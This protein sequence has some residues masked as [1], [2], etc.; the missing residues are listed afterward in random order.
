[1]TGAASVRFGD[2][3]FEL[4]AERVAWWA[5]A[6][7]V[8][9]ADL[10]WGKSQTFRALGVP[11]PG[12][13]LG[14]DLE[15]L[16]QVLTRTGARRLLVVGDLVHAPQ[17]VTEEVA[18]EVTAWRRRHPVS[19]VLVR[20][21]HDRRV[22]RW[23]EGWGV[24][25]CDDVLREDRLAFVHDPDAAPPETW[26]VSGHIH[27]VVRVGRGRTS[28]RLPCFHVGARRL[29]LPAFSSFTGGVCL[30]RRVGDRVFAIAGAAVMQV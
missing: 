7:T 17:G 11:V 12:A 4:L 27:P 21:N 16:G 30:P 19:L 8:V 14:V 5:A 10:H 22:T 13:E 15:R 2:A 24:E 18:A 28:L 9:A 23:P 25:C 29:V 26:T 20:G 6:D 1:M 3:S